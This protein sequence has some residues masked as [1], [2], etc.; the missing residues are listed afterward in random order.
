ML[1]LVIGSCVAGHFILEGEISGCS[2]T[3]GKRAVWRRPTDVTFRA[4][5]L[6]VALFSS[7]VNVNKRCARSYSF[8]VNIIHLR[9]FFTGTT[10]ISESSNGS[11]SVTSSR[12]P[13]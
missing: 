10:V 6:L 4:R 7:T 8:F 12:E 11:Q 5:C 9:Y 1:G 3:A 2:A 13:L